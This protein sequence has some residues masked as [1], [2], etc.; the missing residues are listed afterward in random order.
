M[1][2]AALNPSCE[3]H[4][5]PPRHEIGRPAGAYRGEDT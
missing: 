1:G 5:V 2:F 3:L 4:I